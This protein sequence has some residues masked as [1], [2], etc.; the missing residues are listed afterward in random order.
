MRSCV[1]PLTGT[2]GSGKT[3]VPTLLAER[4][5]RARICEDD[6]WLDR[7]G[8][9][10][11]ALRSETHRQKRGQI[12]DL[13]LRQVAAALESGRKVV[14]DA[15]VHEAPPHAY[16]EYMAEFA[17]HGIRWT[18]RALYP[19]VDVAIDR[20]ATRECWSVGA[21]GVR[22]PHDKFSG[23]VFSRAYLVDNSD[24]TSEDTVR[25]LLDDC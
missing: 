15:T 1:L 25:R 11:G 17:R 16:E 7:F 8:H 13:V 2:C 18:L 4:D 21:A 6:L 22:D 14:I 19:W 23:A 5:D 12:H 3:T 20:D 10:R 24:E 9:D